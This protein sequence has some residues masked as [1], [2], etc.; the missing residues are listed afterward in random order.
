MREK[1]FVDPPYP[2][3]FGRTI[4]KIGCFSQKGLRY[5]FEILHG[6]VSNKNM[7]IPMEMGVGEGVELKIYLNMFSYV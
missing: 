4:D 6:V 2:P 5:S 3:Y 7:K 1:N